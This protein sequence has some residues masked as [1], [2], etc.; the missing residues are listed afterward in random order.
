MG[1]GVGDIVNF[2]P[3]LVFGWPAVILALALAAWG[4]TKRT[5]LAL[6]LAAVIVLPFSFYLA[7]SPSL[8][9]MAALAPLLIASAAVAVRHRR[10]G[11]A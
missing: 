3:A 4:I 6:V 10:G 9:W 11:V 7:S 1:S 8:G 2:W 5:P